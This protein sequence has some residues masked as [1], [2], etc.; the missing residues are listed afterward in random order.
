MRWLRKNGV[1]FEQGTRHLLAVRGQR[2]VAVPRHPS[3]E[4]KTGTAM[5]ILKELDLFDAW[6]KE[7]K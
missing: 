2:R 5:A 6:M 4:V 3:A 1:R 7:R